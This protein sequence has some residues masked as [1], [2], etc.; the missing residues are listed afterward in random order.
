MQAITP[1]ETKN[2][3]HDAEVIARLTQ[4]GLFPTAHVSRLGTRQLR[5]LLRFRTFLLERRPRFFVAA[6]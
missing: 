6:I 1:S 5:S 4:A 3:Q 2:D